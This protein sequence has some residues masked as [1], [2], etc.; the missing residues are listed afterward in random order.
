MPLKPRSMFWTEFGHNLLVVGRWADARQYLQRALAEGMTP[1][2]PISS[3]S[4]T[5]SKGSSDE[6]ER[7]WRLALQWDADRSGT[8]W[9]IGKLELQRGRAAEAIEPLRRAASIQ[10][11]AVG[12]LYSLGLAYRRLGRGEEADRCMKL[13]RTP[14]RE[15]RHVITGRHGWVAPRDRGDGP[16]RR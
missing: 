9:R 5:I 4:P 13:A 6:A 7:C 1:R 11:N 16:L 15:A 10:P 8:W 12:P 3:A 14:P 2:S